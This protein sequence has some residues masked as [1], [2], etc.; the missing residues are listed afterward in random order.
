MAG[1]RTPVISAA[2]AA[3]VAAGLLLAPPAAAIDSL[4]VGAAADTFLNAAQPT[5]TAGG[6][7]GSARVDDQPKIGLFRFDVTGIP[8]G[9]PV[10]SATLTL[11]GVGSQPTT[12]VEL[13][14][15]S[16]QW[17]ETSSYASRP[18]LG[19]VLDT[20][21]IGANGY[22]TFTVPVT[23]NGPVSVAV[24]RAA[25]GNDNLIATRENTSAVSRPK[26]TVDYGSTLVTPESQRPGAPFIPYTEDSFFREALPTSGVPIAA[27]SA[28]GIAYAQ[29]H[30]PYDYPRIR[31]VQGNPWGQPYVL[32]DCD[33][34]VWRV[35]IRTDGEHL[36][37]FGQGNGWLGT[38]GFHAPAS[39]VDRFTGTSDSPFTVID[40]CGSTAMPGGFTVWGFRAMKGT[41]PGTVLV[42]QALAMDATSNGLDRRNPLSNGPANNGSRG[43]ILGSEVIRD[44]LLAYAQQGGN[45][46]T[47]GHV[48]EMFWLET[49]T[50]A[51]HVHPMVGHEA[52]KTGYG[53][54]GIRIRVKESW[55][56][57]DACTGPGLVIARTLQR[58]G[59]V[60]GDNSGSGSAIKAEQG[61]TYP[62]LTQ[63]ALASCV[64]WGDME[65][66]QPGYQP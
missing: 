53:A 7:A 4:T 2:A 49:N 5:S 54:E 3:V 6:A 40:T 46:G 59:A 14:A 39:F 66:V 58:Y 13:R 42:A 21:T 63:D 64:T 28:T 19:A 10:T 65:F 26:L 25:A 23:S 20:A 9:A 8:T 34:P 47:L 50:T 16:G 57:T 24:T 51:G 55:V 37:G 32:S 56:P 17:N 33:D 29:Q 27:N 62:G 52:D 45:D 44:D 22:A 30:D 38:Q 1:S 31:G 61:S 36:Y 11:R 15:V 43:N 60:I 35:K 18:V 48:L 41:E 12:L